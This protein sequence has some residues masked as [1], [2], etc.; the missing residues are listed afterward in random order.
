MI[1][2]SWNLAIIGN[3]IRI[4]VRIFVKNVIKGLFE[5]LAKDCLTSKIGALRTME[6]L[7]FRLGDKNGRPILYL[8]EDHLS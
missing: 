7:G 2:A 6:T 4:F 5:D 1:Q 8:R 3:F